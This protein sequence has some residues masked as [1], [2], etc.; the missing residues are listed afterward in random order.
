M[1]REAF[2]GNSRFAGTWWHAFRDKPRG[3]QSLASLLNVYIP[4]VVKT[5]R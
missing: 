1:E 2:R 4:L 5:S 3:A